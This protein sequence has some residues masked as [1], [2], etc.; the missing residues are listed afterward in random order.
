MQ[1]IINSIDFFQRF[2]CP[3]I[4][5]VDLLFLLHKTKILGKM[6]SISKRR[7]IFSFIFVLSFH[8]KN[9]EN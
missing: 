1:L 2:F 7:V 6:S 3:N 5:Y 8:W 9:Y 4:S